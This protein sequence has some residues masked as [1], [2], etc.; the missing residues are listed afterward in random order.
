MA[1]LGPGFAAGGFERRSASAAAVWHRP[2][3]EEF[4]VAWVQPTRSPDAY[5]WYGSRFI[6]EFRRGAQPR[7]GVLG[8]GFR[9]CQL[10]DDEARERVRAVQNAVIRRMP[11]APVRVLR[12]LDDQERDRYLAQGRQVTAPYG[13]DQDVWFRYRDER[14]LNAWFRLLPVLLPGVLR[15]VRLRLG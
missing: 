9:F 7:A 8:P 15:V 3:G 12:T 11:P 1:A 13:P 5:G 4:V 14:D 6:I 2:A 10:V